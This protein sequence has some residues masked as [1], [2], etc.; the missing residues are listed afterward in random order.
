[1][2]TSKNRGLGKGLEALFADVEIEIGEEGKSKKDGSIEY[3]NVHDIKPNRSQPRQN[4]SEE[5]IDE[6]ADS[7][8]THGLIQPIVLRQ[9]STGYEIVAG[10][11]RWRAAIKAGLKE[12][13]GIIR[14]LSD[15]QNALMAIIE[16]M[17]RED[18][19][20]IEEAMGLEKMASNFGLTQEEISKGIGK[21]RPYVANAMRLLKLPKS[22]Q[23]MVVEGLLTGGHARVLAGLKDEEEIVKA[24]K[25]CI[26]QGWTVRDIES[27]SQKNSSESGKHKAKARSKNRDLLNLE[28]EL[29]DTLGTKV[30]IVV[31]A[32]KGKIEIEYYSRNELDR[33][34]ELLQSLKK[35]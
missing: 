25:K 10:E 32:K 24:A 3:I 2:K 34:I 18:L 22:I 28:D 33:L 6:L 27:Y 31:G 14:V 7:I 23:E 5:K 16:N 29:K 12:I 20:P 8:K 9:L 17:Q 35:S 11:R 26:E 4:F 13:P 15:E 1:M 21:S 19:N 30:N